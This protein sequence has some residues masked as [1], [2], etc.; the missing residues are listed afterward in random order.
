MDLQRGTLRAREGFSGPIV[1]RKRDKGSVT[2]FGKKFY[3]W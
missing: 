1:V 3:F 2:R